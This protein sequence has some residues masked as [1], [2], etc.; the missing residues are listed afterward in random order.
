MGRIIARVLIA[1]AA[2]AALL[3][4]AVLVLILREPA[5]TPTPLP[6]PN[7]YDK[8]L[9]A[10]KLVTD[11]TAD[12][13]ELSEE[14]LRAVVLKNAEALRMAR[15][16]LTQQS[17]VPIFLAAT[18]WD[19]HVEQLPGMKRVAHAFAAEGQVA[20]LDN[21]PEAAARSYLDAIQ[22]GHECARGGT[23]ID[24]LVGLADES[25]GLSGLEKLDSKLDSKECRKVVAALEEM[26]SKREPVSEILQ[27]EKEW[28]RAQFGWQTPILRLISYRQTQAARQKY[29]SKMINAQK[30]AGRVAIQFAERAYELEH[31][32]KAKEI[33]NLVPNYL[34]TIPKD[35]VSGKNLE[36]HAPDGGV[37]AH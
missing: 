10:G 11:E 5:P 25:I 21:R 19:A 24:S 13:N 14:K 23:I 3:V 37:T 26:E 7:G 35:P 33:E 17:R 32:E 16:G 27:H 36:A 18:N 12:R 6:V 31:G 29:L 22:F 8:F 15:E 2:I 9:E 28:S 34:K 20:E 1:F 30:R 4:I